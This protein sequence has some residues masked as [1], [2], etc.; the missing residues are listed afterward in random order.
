VRLVYFTLNDYRSA[1][2]GIFSRPDLTVTESCLAYLNSENVKAPPADP[3]S[4]P[5]IAP[6]V[7]ESPWERGALGSRRITRGRDVSGMIIARY[8][9]N[10]F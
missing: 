9:P 1:R 3:P 4:H 10:G 5:Q 2:P 7:L 6:S 8:V